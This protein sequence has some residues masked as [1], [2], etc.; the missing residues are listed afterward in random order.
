MKKLIIATA[1]ILLSITSAHAE[2]WSNSLYG[3]DWAAQDGVDFPPDF[4][5][6]SYIDKDGVRGWEWECQF[7]HATINPNLVRDRVTVAVNCSAEGNEYTETVAID[8]LDG[9]GY[10][11]QPSEGEAMWFKYKC[12]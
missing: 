12:D 11:V 2:I 5:S 7:G 3:C 6:I 10:I 8:S 9:F 4:E 1:T